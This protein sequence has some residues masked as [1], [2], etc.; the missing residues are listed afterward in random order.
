MSED[1][2]VKAVRTLEFD[3]IRDE[4]ASLCLTEASKE[5]ARNLMPSDVPVVVKQTLDET[6]DAKAMQRI[7]GMP[8]FSGIINVRDSMEK[9]E[10]GATLTTEE[11]LGIGRALQAAR[12]VKDYGNTDHGEENSLTQYFNSIRPVESL[13]RHISKCIISVDMIS[14]EAS[15]K[16]YDIRRHIRH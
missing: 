13:E 12:S 15:E 10:K 16:L 11:L 9:A 2:F 3:K 14:D 6:T 1:S 8:S 5:M 7:K 4:L